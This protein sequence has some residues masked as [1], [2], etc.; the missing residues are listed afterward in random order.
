MEIEK[1]LLKGRDRQE[2]GKDGLFG[3]KDEP[4][5][6]VNL[7]ACEGGSRDKGALGHSF[8]GRSQLMIG[9]SIPM[10]VDQQARSGELE[11]KGSQKGSVEGCGFNDDLMPKTIQTK[12]EAPVC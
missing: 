1:P 6:G 3:K 9:F 7:K 10:Q 8:G 11:V 4:K 2:G 12:Q 5:R